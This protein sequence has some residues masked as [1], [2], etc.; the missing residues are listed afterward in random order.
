MFIHGLITFD[1]TFLRAKQITVL[2][3]HNLL[4]PLENRLI[5][6]PEI[7]FNVSIY[8]SNEISSRNN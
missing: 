7:V 5:N 6:Y 4:Q 8:N 2:T 3:L 1:H